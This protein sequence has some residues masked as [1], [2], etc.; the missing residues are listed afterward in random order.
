MR[1]KKAQIGLETGG[2]PGDITW[3]GDEAAGG[4]QVSVLVR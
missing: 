1:G 3:K 2:D 4:T